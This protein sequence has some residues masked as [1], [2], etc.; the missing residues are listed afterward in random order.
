VNRKELELRDEADILLQDV[1]AIMDSAPD[2]EPPDPEPVPP[3]EQAEV[4]IT[5]TAN[6]PVK[7]TIN[8][9]TVVE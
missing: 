2:P 4:N 6:G 5:L 7:V 3:G 1:Q 9:Q 8:G